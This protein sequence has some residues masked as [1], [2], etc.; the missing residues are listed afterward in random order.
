MW[1]DGIDVEVVGGNLELSLTNTD[2]EKHLVA[3]IS[4]QTA[5]ELG[6][7]LQAMGLPPV[8]PPVAP[9]AILHHLDDMR[10][11]AL[12]AGYCERGKR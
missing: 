2:E 10:R 4:P 9:E 1:K 3:S 11:L 5:A 8:P 7:K 12:G 6:R